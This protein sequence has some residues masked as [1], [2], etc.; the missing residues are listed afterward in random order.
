MLLAYGADPKATDPKGLTP[1]DVARDR[2]NVEVASALHHAALE[3]G[4]R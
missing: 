4:Q 2:K 3:Q 1:L